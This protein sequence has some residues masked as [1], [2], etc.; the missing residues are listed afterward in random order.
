MHFDVKVM[1]ATL[2]TWFLVKS[3]ATALLDW[4]QEK[5]SKEDIVAPCSF[6]AL[7]IE[8]LCWLESST[9]A[10]NKLKQFFKKRSANKRTA[11]GKV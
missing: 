6:G 2:C 5:H 1:E 10:L 7:R 9:T 3:I 8:D 11:E 4:Q